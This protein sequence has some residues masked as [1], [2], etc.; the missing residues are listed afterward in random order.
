MI[1]KLAGG[2]TE[3]TFD[4]G[5]VVRYL[6]FGGLAVVTSESPTLRLGTDAFTDYLHAVSMSVAESRE[7]LDD[8]DCYVPMV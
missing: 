3:W 6:I 8:G 7:M 5:K 1:R 2:A 4:N